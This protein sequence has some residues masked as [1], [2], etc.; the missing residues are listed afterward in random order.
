MA[1]RIGPQAGIFGGI[2]GFSFPSPPFRTGWRLG[3]KRAEGRID[4]DYLD[5]ALEGFSGY[6]AADELYDGPY[7]VLSIVDNHTFKRIGVE[8][9]KLMHASPALCGKRRHSWPA[10]MGFPELPTC[11]GSAIAR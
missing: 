8:L 3:G 9:V 6:I 4:V 11:C 7:C 1:C 10:G 5:G 2:I